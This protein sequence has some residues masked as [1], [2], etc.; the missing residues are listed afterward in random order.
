MN[1]KDFRM[2]SDL[3]T[4][5]DYACT[6]SATRVLLAEDDSASCRFLADGLRQM[7]VQVTACEEG[8]QALACA[9]VEAF[10]LLLLDCHMPGAGALTILAALRA[11]PHAASHASVAVA[12]SA[13]FTPD[14]RRALFAAGFGA[15]L[16]KP[17]TLAQLRAL[18]ALTP[19]PRRV[20]LNDDAGL[21]SSGDHATLQALRQLLHAELTEL[22]RQL[23]GL[24][25]DRAALDERLHRLRAACGFCGADELSA[26]AAALQMAASQNAPDAATLARFRS[27]LQITLR[28][29]QG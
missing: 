19:A 3:A 21:R 11:D 20:A 16:C 18:L 29:L 8:R 1:D 6:K 27:V 22:D 15:A 12:T 5:Y 28:T 13:A 17:C 4:P 26:A 2:C 25:H 23:D 10:D 9:R 14:E 24:G 7:A